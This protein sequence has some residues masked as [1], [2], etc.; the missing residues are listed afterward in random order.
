METKRPY[1]PLPGWTRWPLRAAPAGGAGPAGAQLEDAPSVAWTEDG[2]CARRGWR[3]TAARGPCARLW[4]D[5]F[6]PGL[7]EDGANITRKTIRSD[8]LAVTV[9]I[10]MLEATEATL[11]SFP[12][13]VI[14]KASK[15]LVVYLDFRLPI[16]ARL[17][18]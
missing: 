15:K 10:N 13:N 11:S 1:A 16:K 5:G 2:P 9:P 6:E 8:H 14:L 7:H 17:E 3:T 4:Q 12:S 18:G